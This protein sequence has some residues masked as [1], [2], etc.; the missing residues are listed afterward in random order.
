MH[1]IIKLY[2]LCKRFHRCDRGQALTE[3]SIAMVMIVPL[4][5]F[6]FMPDNELFEGI[7]VIFD[8]TRLLILLPGP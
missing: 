3:Y 4:C 7:R 6:L 5:I 8:D 2:Y 1:F